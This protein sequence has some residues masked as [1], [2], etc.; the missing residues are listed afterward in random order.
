MQ[1]IT[2]NQ[3]STDGYINIYFLV[4]V[5]IEMNFRESNSVKPKYAHHIFFRGP[6]Q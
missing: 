6:L 4:A 3:I 1:S 2:V 5:K